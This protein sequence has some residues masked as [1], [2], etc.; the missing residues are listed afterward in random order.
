MNAS[1]PHTKGSGMPMSQRKAASST[2]TISPN[3]VETTR[4]TRV[5][6]ANEL[7]AGASAPR[8]ARVR[9]MRSVNAEASSD[10]KNSRA[11][12]KARLDSTPKRSFS[13]SAR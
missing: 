3:T 1:S 12:T 2:A 9:P 10:M 4:Y 7:R 11:T 5:P 8:P 6:C 13:R